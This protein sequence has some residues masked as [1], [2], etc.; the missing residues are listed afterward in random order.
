MAQLTTQLEPALVKIDPGIVTEPRVG[1]A[2]SRIYCDLRYSKGQLYRDSMWLS[3]KRDKHAYPFY[4]EFFFV[5]TPNEYFY[6]CGYYY[7]AANAAE[8]MRSMIVDNAPPFKKALKAFESQSR[9][10]I[11]GEMYKKTKY[12]QQPQKLRDWLDRK[13]ISLIYRGTDK[14]LLFSDDLW[15]TVSDD[16]TSVASVYNFFITVQEKSI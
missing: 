5:I 13:S 1:R 15:R 2:I 8:Y 9:F 7:M 10:V 4:P 6:G 11:D 12:P 14:E 16:F 3:L